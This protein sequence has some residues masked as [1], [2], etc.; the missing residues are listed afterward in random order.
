M[1]LTYD[2]I[3]AQNWV[4]QLKADLPAAGR[5]IN[6]VGLR[7]Y[8][9]QDGVNERAVMMTIHWRRCAHPDVMQRRYND[10]RYGN[11]VR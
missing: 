9:E 2:K 7:E 11:L 1:R 6:E 3:L 8:C 10:I 4:E 5:G